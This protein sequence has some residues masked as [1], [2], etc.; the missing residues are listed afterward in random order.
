MRRGI[1]RLLLGWIYWTL[2]GSRF[3]LILW[4]KITIVC[5]LVFLRLLK[6]IGWWILIS[7]NYR[8]WRAWSI[9]WSCLTAWS[10]YT[11]NNVILRWSS[12]FRCNIISQRFKIILVS[13][14]ILSLFTKLPNRWY[15]ISLSISLN[16]ITWMDLNTHINIIFKNIQWFY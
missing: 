1:F 9:V 8:G 7:L 14:L 15:F 16:I 13:L 12:L 3:F 6:L 5:F 4:V 11:L 2:W 10:S